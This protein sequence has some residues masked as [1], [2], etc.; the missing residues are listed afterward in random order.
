MKS[1]KRTPSSE[2]SFTELKYQLIRNRLLIVTRNVQAMSI[3]TR[4]GNAF[5]KKGATLSVLPVENNNPPVNPK[6]VGL[7]LSQAL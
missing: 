4:M 5:E 2:P 7:E 6:Q 1:R 3:T